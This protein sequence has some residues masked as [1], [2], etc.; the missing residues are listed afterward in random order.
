MASEQRHI[1]DTEGGDYLRRICSHVI[2]LQYIQWLLPKFF[3]LLFCATQ[4]HL[5][6]NGELDKSRTATLPN[7]AGFGGRGREL[8]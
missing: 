6:G 1:T 7:A 3:S 8:T 5:A 4:T 2:P